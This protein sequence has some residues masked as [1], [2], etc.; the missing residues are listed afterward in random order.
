MKHKKFRKYTRET[1]KLI[2]WLIND[3]SCYLQG[4]DAGSRPSELHKY[5]GKQ[6]LKKLFLKHRGVKLSELEPFKDLYGK[7]QGKILDTLK[8]EITDDNKT[9]IIC[10]DV[11]CILKEEFQKLTMVLDGTFSLT[12]NLMNQKQANSFVTWMFEFFMDNNIEMRKEIQELYIKQNAEG[13]VYY[14]LLNKRCAVCGAEVVDL[15]HYDHIGS[16]GYEYD[17][18]KQTRFM[19]LCRKHHNLAHNIPKKEFESKYFMS[20]IWLKDDQIKELKKIY[21]GHFK[22]FKEAQND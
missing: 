20:G 11:E 9:G 1:Q 15:H 17:D 18:G 6:E 4:L 8:M 13:Y 14:C 10:D 7:L 22:A 12:L 2:Y 19:S 21:K 16:T 5:K 3:Y